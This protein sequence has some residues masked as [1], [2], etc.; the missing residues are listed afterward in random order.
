MSVRV[1]VYTDQA[2][3]EARKISTPRRIAVAH[4]AAGEA[5]ADA[6]VRSGEY[7]DGIGVKVEGER[8]FLV[9]EDPESIHKEYGTRDTPAHAVLTDAARRHGRYSG[10]QPKG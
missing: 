6:P 3:R 4:Q 1:T 5:R 2:L 7:R 9:D 10:W 8:V